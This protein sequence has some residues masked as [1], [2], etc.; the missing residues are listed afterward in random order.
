[1]NTTTTRRDEGPPTVPSDWA[2]PSRAPGPTHH[3]LEFTGSGSEYFRIWI[4]NLLLTL[5]TLGLYYPWAKVRKLRYFHGNTRLA[6]HGFDFHGEPLRMLRGFLLVGVL[7]AVYAFAGQVSPVAG[8]V[9]IVILAA[10]WP[11]LLRASMR[12]RLAQ[13]SWRGLRFHFAGDTAGAYVALLPSLA[14]AVMFVATSAL[15]LPDAAEAGGRPAPMSGMAAFFLFASLAL[16][17]AAT[18]LTMWLLKR[19]QHG[20]Y[21]YA[22]VRTRFTAGAGAFLALFA[23]AFGILL[24]CVLAGGAIAVLF[25]V[26]G[27]MGGGGRGRSA[28]MVIVMTL[29]VIAVYAVML[30]ALQPYIVSRLQNLV[31]NHTESRAIGFDSRLRFWPLARLTAINWFLIVVTLGLYWPFAAVATAR[32]RLQAVDVIARTDLDALVA[33]ATSGSD[34]AAGDAAADVFG[35]DLGL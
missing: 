30:F 33:R 9:A 27:A 7:F 35:L 19:W 25:G 2:A 11:A 10:I 8:V 26:V 1:M 28:L 15:G 20:H 22:S 18:P 12:F 14:A 17:F 23:K 4:V 13:T 6:G 3:G 21:Q 29:S 24:L 31:W 16:M 5:V 34:D 32:L